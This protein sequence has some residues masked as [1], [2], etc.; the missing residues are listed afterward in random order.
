MAQQTRL[1][2]IALGLIVAGFLLAVLEGGLSYGILVRDLSR[3]SMSRQSLP[4]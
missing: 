3:L 1:K 2:K 4:I